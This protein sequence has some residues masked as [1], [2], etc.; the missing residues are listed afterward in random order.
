MLPDFLV[1]SYRQYKADTKFLATWL[2]VTARTLGYVS[3]AIPAKQD[4]IETKPNK[5]KSKAKPKTKKQKR[6]A[7][8]RIPKEQRKIVISQKEFLPLAQYIASNLKPPAKVPSSI[9]PTIT[10]VIEA[11]KDSNEWFAANSKEDDNGGHMFFIKTLQDVYDTL[12]PFVK[13]TE[14]DEAETTGDLDDVKNLFK[15]LDIEEPSQTFLNTPGMPAPDHTGGRMLCELMDFFVE[16]LGSQ[17]E[18]SFAASSLFRD[19]NKIY[20]HVEQTWHQYRDGKTDLMTASIISNTAVELIRRLE[21]D[22]FEQFPR[23][24]NIEKDIVS[25]YK[26]YKPTHKDAQQLINFMFRAKCAK[27]NRDPWSNDEQ[28]TQFNLEYYDD[29]RH[30]FLD[31]QAIFCSYYSGSRG[32]TKC[33]YQPGEFGLWDQDAQYDKLSAK[34]RYDQDCR[35]LREIMPDM[36]ILSTSLSGIPALA[37]DEM[38]RGSRNFVA[39][40]GNAPVMHLWMLVSLRIF[41]DIHH[42]LGGNIGKPFEA[43]R[44]LGREANDAV[45]EAMRQ[46]DS[47]N[48]DFWP[49]NADTSVKENFLDRVQQSLFVD[50]VKEYIDNAARNVKGWQ[51]KIDFELLRRHPWACGLMEF[52][53]RV[54]LEETGLAALHTT[55]SAL[56]ASHLYNALQQEGILRTPWPD[57]EL[58]MDLLSDEQLFRGERPARLDEYY[59]RLAVLR[60]VSAETFAHNRRDR[61]FILSKRGRRILGPLSELLNIL[62][63]RYVLVKQRPETTDEEGT[64][65]LA[66]IEEA[67]NKQMQISSN[68]T[69]ATVRAKD[70]NDVR[71]Q[72]K[73]V[74]QGRRKYN[75]VELLMSLQFGLARD[76]PV[77]MFDYLAFHKSCWEMLKSCY[78]VCSPLLLA[79]IPHAFRDF[80]DKTYL[81]L[82]GCVDFLLII[83]ISV[84]TGHKMIRKVVMLNLPPITHE[85]QQMFNHRAILRSVSS[86]VQNKIENGRLRVTANVKARKLIATRPEV[87]H[88]E[89]QTVD[90]GDGHITF[91]KHKMW[92]HEDSSCTK[93]RCVCGTKPMG[94]LKPGWRRALSEN[95]EILLGEVA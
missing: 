34:E 22:F 1:G 81:R 48:A 55:G 25:N 11:R 66:D 79:H 21:E 54:C 26:A 27:D 76:L 84:T 33:V 7:A 5:S 16:Y 2:I 20:R 43:I 92:K 3:E 74:T 12:H 9:L 61:G 23:F 41:C 24:R 8:R 80:E 56:S 42:I 93:D 85:F 88:F 78:D 63:H 45:K 53:I 86:A 15:H 67:L 6:D 29:A 62:K 89:V 44:K 77:L 19:I 75:P 38:L 14:S 94:M 37:E 68:G 82:T 49:A 59:P 58:F 28:G 65:I 13:S 73:T 36:I 72:N 70:Q 71:S 87:I 31:I 69:S 18:E 64:L 4:P 46:R 60:G 47:K 95:A 51:G 35:I 40:P 17:L 83:G 50:E 52:N 90:D 10:R 91:K 39:Q 57:M 30:V 32:M